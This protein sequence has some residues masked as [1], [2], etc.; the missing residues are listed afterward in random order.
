MNIE[1][2]MFMKYRNLLPSNATG[3]KTIVSLSEDARIADLY[4][5]FGIPDAEP[6]LIIING[7]SK[8]TACSAKDETLRD[9][10]IVAIFPPAAGG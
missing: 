4:A 5:M 6:K 3:G 7:I 1:V 2:R 8:G 9:G 10:D